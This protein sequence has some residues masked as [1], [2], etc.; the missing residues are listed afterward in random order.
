MLVLIDYI[1][2]NNG[3][4]NV[5]DARDGWTINY[6]AQPR[7]RSVYDPFPGYGKLA[8]LLCHVI[9]A[10][11]FSWI[12]RCLCHSSRYGGVEVMQGFR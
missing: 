1:D 12:I 3:I 4:R 11:K 9:S 10:N 6:E 5:S 8:T 2:C 7:T